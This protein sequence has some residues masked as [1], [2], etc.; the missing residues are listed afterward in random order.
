LIDQGPW[1]PE[2]FVQ[3]ERPLARAFGPL[4][5]GYL[6]LGVAHVALLPPWEGF[7][8]P[9]HYS[10]IQQV[11]DT[12]SL[13]A[14][15]SARISDDVERYRRDGPMPYAGRPPFERNGGLTYR[16]FFDERAETPRAGRTL[17]H[18]RPREGR[19]YRPGPAAN[20]EA[21]HPPLYYVALAPLYRATRHWSWGSHLF[22]L[23][24]ASYLFAWAAWAAAL[25]GCLAALARPPARPGSALPWAWAALGTAAWPL[26]LPG[27]FPEFAR[28][29]ND[30]L[31]ALV[32]TAL[33][34]VNVRAARAGLDLRRAVALGALLGAGALTKALF[35][36][37]AAGTAAFWL[38]NAWTTK[39]E[40]AR[41]D[42][43]VRL[44]LAL[45]VAAA[46]A[47]WWYVLDDAP[48][49]FRLWPEEVETL[50][51]AGGLPAGLRTNFTFGAWLRGQAALVTT[52][53]WSG[54]WSLARPPSVFLAPL[55]AL[56]VSVAVGY[57]WSLRRRRPGELAWLPA[58]LAAP[59]VAGLGYHV[60]LRLAL[61]GEALTPGYYLHVLVA[62]LGCALG[63]ALRVAVARP[64]GRLAAGALAAYAVAFGLAISWAQVLMFSGYLVKQGSSKLYQAAAPWTALLDAPQVLGRLETLAFPA[65]G[66]AAFAAGGLLVLAGALAVWRSVRAAESGP[67]RT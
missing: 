34:W 22:A 2:P 12:A 13:P 50:R 47:G 60:L 29:G 10:Y 8:E 44:L 7:D 18:D 54:T 37:L 52:V 57:L 66:A 30:S 56:V 14:M 67:R 26:L 11:A 28:L 15:A 38:L 62:P 43:A 63:L 3:G 49:V 61:T 19:G 4:A 55:A 25:Y 46:I 58:W 53:A 21:Q 16:T 23:R 1:G 31:S 40:D 24:L 5:A 51:Q 65:L 17:I 45:A 39:D 41:R 32:A 20:W 9:A 42:V 27:W 6:L 48:Y 64:A 36:P 35:L 33:W 59:L